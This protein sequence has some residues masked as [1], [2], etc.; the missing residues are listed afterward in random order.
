MGKDATEADHTDTLIIVSIN[1]ETQTAAMVSLPRDL[2]VYVPGKV[3]SRI[4]TALTLGGPELL[5]DTILYNLGIP[6]DYWAQVDFNG[7]VQIVNSLGGVVA[8]R[9]LWFYRFPP[10]LT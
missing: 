8:G 1:K 3:M 9:D 7:F 10:H 5:V 4:N 2:F 6:I